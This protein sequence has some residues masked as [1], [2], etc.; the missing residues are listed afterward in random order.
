MGAVP[1]CSAFMESRLKHRKSAHCNCSS[2]P[3]AHALYAHCFWIWNPAPMA[4][5]AYV[6]VFDPDTV[7]DLVS[8]GRK[9]VAERTNVRDNS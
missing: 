7:S 3:L 4:D 9:R 5:L 2:E 1:S 8:R 6:R